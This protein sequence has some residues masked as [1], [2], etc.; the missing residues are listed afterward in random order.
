MCP[1]FV[2]P[3]VPHRED[4]AIDKAQDYKDKEATDEWETDEEGIIRVVGWSQ[5]R[6]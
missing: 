5:A 3:L 6:G 1:D 2:R 4:L